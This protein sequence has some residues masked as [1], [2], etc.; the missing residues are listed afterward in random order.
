MKT[1]IRKILLKAVGVRLYR[2]LPRGVDLP[3]DLTN[4]FQTLPMEVIFDV[5]ANVGQT[6]TTY[7]THF[8]HASIYA[9]EPVPAVY[10]TLKWATR[11]LPNVRCVNLGLGSSTAKVKMVMNIP[12][13]NETWHIVNPDQTTQ[14][15]PP[16]SVAAEVVT[17]DEYCITHAIND[18]S[19]F[20][21]DTEGH[22]LNVLAGAQRM[23]A[24][25]KI[26]FIQVEASM[27]RSNH[28]HNSWRD[29]TD[30]LESYSFFLFGI[31]DQAPESRDA[32]GQLRRANLVFMSDAARDSSHHSA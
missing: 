4:A 11:R 5:G 8:P 21:I 16:S 12:P 24:D 10:E 29:L 17:L 27:N 14:Q 25:S 15:Y 28:F 13:S 6:C 1:L 2:S 30:F 18:I 32:G 19:L 3:Y 7:A 31:Y 9:F 22:D 20:K 23:L 26:R